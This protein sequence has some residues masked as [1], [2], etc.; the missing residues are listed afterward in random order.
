MKH[1]TAKVSEEVNRK[2]LLGTWR[3]ERLYWPWA[4]QCTALQTDGQ[5]EDVM[6]PIADYTAPAARLQSLRSTSVRTRRN[7]NKRHCSQYDL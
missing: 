3:L 6:M 5:T 1:P 4:P 2:C 7:Q